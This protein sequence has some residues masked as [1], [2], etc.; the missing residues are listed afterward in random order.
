MHSVRAITADFGFSFGLP[1]PTF[2]AVASA[3]PPIEP[4]AKRRKTSGGHNENVGDAQQPSASYGSRAEQPVVGQH[5]SCTEQ[6]VTNTQTNPVKKPQR[7][8][9][10]LQLEDDAE[11][12][13]KSI[14]KPRRLQR[15]FQVEDDVKAQR[16]IC[17]S[18]KKDTEDDRQTQSKPACQLPAAVA[19]K[20][21]A[22]SADDTFIFGVKPKKRRAEKK[23]QESATKDVTL[24]SG[25]G[26]PLDD[27]TTEPTQILKPPER[28]A[29]EAPRTETAEAEKPSKRVQGRIFTKQ[30][31]ETKQPEVRAGDTA[32]E[33]GTIPEKS[34]KATKAKP[35]TKKS[36]KIAAISEVHPKQLEESAV[37]AS[38]VPAKAAKP[39]KAKSAGK[40]VTVAERP[41]NTDVDELSFSTSDAP[42]H[43]V[44]GTEKPSK[45]T[46]SK[47]LAEPSAKAAITPQSCPTEDIK[48]SEGPQTTTRRPRRQA[49]ISANQKVA[50]G[51]EEELVPVDKLRRAPE[52]TTE[53]GR[54][55]K[56]VA[57]QTLPTQEVSPQT[58][59]VSLPTDAARNKPEEGPVCSERKPSKVVRKAAGRTAKKKSASK[60]TTEPAA[61]IPEPDSSTVPAPKEQ[62]AAIGEPDI[63]VNNIP[64]DV[65]KAATIMP[66]LEKRRALAESD[67]NISKPSPPQATTDEPVKDKKIEMDHQDNDLKLTMKSSRRP[68]VAK[69]DPAPASLRQGDNLLEHQPKTQAPASK[70]SRKP[71]PLVESDPTPDIDVSHPQQSPPKKRKRAADDE[72]LDWLFDKPEV[73]SVQPSNPRVKS[74]TKARRKLPDKAENDMDLDDLLESIA[75]F[76]GKLLTGRNGRVR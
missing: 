49:A 30:E 60:D 14:K 2:E 61:N 4:P 9:R 51:Y 73:R 59:K 22:K 63:A 35:R 23:Q 62:P 36:A 20:V 8:R 12:Q 33:H 47:Q 6:P 70:R 40:K 76:S 48:A 44:V 68:K 37:E 16:T 75:G 41:P 3:N 66:V 1:P 34:T 54:S 26:V 25:T 53:A 32:I 45:A 56:I 39:A 46:K 38:T 21:N 74:A 67:V 28:E 69:Q 7:A 29:K 5:E 27:P 43:A 10:K 58:T 31:V 19:G 13:P 24:E 17:H 64:T 71:Q 57:A 50:M 65:Q 18:T 15:E 72:D 42:A 11:T 52:A 55:R